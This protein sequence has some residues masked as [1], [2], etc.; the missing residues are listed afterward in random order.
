LFGVSAAFMLLPPSTK[1][2]PAGVFL[3]R[4]SGMLF[5][6]NRVVLWAMPALQCLLLLFFIL[7]AVTHVWWNW[8]MLVLAFGAGLLGGAV[9]VDSFTLLSREVA[10]ALRE[11]SLAA[12][13][14]A[15]SLGIAAADVA[16][17]LIQGC[18]FKLQGLPGA[19][20][21]CGGSSWARFGCKQV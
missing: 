3:S 10:P 20:Y 2:H 12:V 14:V 4:S 18:L 6:A 16:A 19:A 21:A 7:D 5:Q 15:D 8:G 1:L 9:Y 13:C 11:F 17:V